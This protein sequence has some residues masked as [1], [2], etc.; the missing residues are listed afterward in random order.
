MARAAAG[1]SE[2][3]GGGMAPPASPSSYIPT[4]RVSVEA[5]VVCVC[6]SCIY[7]CVRVTL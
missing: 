1:A 3:M 6:V 4:G 2:T 7:G 5:C